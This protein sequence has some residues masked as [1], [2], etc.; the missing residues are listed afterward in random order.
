MIL[1]MQQHNL[2]RHP[3]DDKRYEA[4]KP[5]FMQINT[6]VNW[7][8]FRPALEKALDYKPLGQGRKP[9]DPILMFKIMV[10][11][12]FYDLSHD[13]MEFQL[14]DRQSFR[15]FVGLHKN[16]TI[17]DAKT[18][19]LFHDKLA[20][21]DIMTSLFDQVLQQI[22]DHGFIAQGGQ[23]VDASLMESR[24]PTQR[25]TQEEIE[26]LPD[27]V[28]RQVD[29]DA[30]F[31]KKNGKSYHGYKGHT[32]ADVAHK[33]VRQIEITTAKDGDI[34]VLDKLM[35]EDNTKNVFYGDSAYKSEAVEENLSAKA[36]V[37]RINRRAYRNQPLNEHDK[38]FN[39]TSSKVRARVEHVYGQVKLWG[40]RLQ[41]RS[42]GIKRA[43]LGI[44]MKFI[45]YNLG[46]WRFL[47]EQACF[48]V[49]C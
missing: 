19:W 28:R 31:T 15:A 35:D 32:N 37:S 1:T 16:A 2:F 24:K 11:Q 12:H 43:T 45:V 33:I 44:G 39:R 49:V 29:P 9:F 36:I 13:A 27:N 5:K 42:I 10:L 25:R 46:R 14:R 38:R 20:K 23:M 7:Q 4:L 30:T 47:E 8:A 34:T 26:A 48:Q 22:D 40:R 17:P 18:I 21:A 41:V 6:L 3:S